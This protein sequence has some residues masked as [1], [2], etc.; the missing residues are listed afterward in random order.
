ML[1]QSRGIQ[2]SGFLLQKIYVNT[3]EGNSLAGCVFVHREIFVLTPSVFLGTEVNCRQHVCYLSS[4][5]EPQKNPFMSHCFVSSFHP[6]EL[7]NSMRIGHLYRVLGFPAHVQ[8]W[9]SISWSVEANNIQ[10]WEPERKALVW[11]QAF[12]T[13]IKENTLIMSQNHE[14]LSRIGATLVPC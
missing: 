1:T 7:C 6:D 12:S 11:L 13:V 10:L 14:H 4:R 9:Q 2:Y 8:Q 5:R 3:S